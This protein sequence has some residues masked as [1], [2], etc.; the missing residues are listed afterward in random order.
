MSGP[1]GLST[2]LLAAAAVL[3]NV[4]AQVLLKRAAV[5]DAFNLR[6]WL[7]D[8]LLGAVGLYGVGF[9]LT[10]LVFARMPLSVASPLMAGSIFLLVALMSVLAFGE[11]LGVA[12]IV[13]MG[14]ILAG[15]LL[16]SRGG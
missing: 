16:L 2:W 14:L 3:C 8:S 7:D 13:G 4:M 11:S 6:Q 12:K 15:I 1:A 5:T 9:A 10:A